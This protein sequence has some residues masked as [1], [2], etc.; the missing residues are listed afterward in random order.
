MWWALRAAP[1]RR[2]CSVSFARAGDRAEELLDQ[3]GVEVR[4]SRSGGSR[5]SNARNGRPETSIAQAARASSIGT[6]AC[7]K[8]RDAGAVAERLVERLAEHDAH[9]LD[10][11]VGAGLEVALDRRRRGRARRGARRA[12]SMWSKKPTPVPRSPAPVPSSVERRARRR[13]RR[14]SRW[15][16]GGAAHAPALHRLGVHGEAL[17]AGQ[18]GAGGREAGR[19]LAGQ[20]YA[21][22]AAPEGRRATARAGSARRRPWAAR[23]WS[24]RRSRRTPCRAAGADEHAAGARERVGQRLGLGADQL[25]VLGRD[26]LGERE[27]LR[28]RPARHHRERRSATSGARRQAL[29]LGRPRR[30]APRRARYR[31]SGLSAPCSAWASRSSATSSGSAPSAA[32]TTSS[33]GPGEPVDAHVAEHLALGL[34]TQRVARARD[35]VDRRAR[36]RCRRPARRSPARRPSGRPR[37]PA[38]HAGGEDHRVGPA[39]GPRRRAHRYLAAPRPR[40]RSP[41]T[42][43]R[44]TD[45]PPGRPARR[46]PRGRPA[47]RRPRRCWPCGQLDRDRLA[48]LRLAPPRARSRSPC[49]GRRARRARARPRDASSSRASHPQLLGAAA[50]PCRSAR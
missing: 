6:T 18:G 44:W 48:Q 4:R 2:T 13:S 12:S 39:A 5:A 27:R 19:R 8:R 3:V 36:S 43:P 45:T 38:E 11:V 34:L 37:Y 15:I 24:R 42:S 33:L 41:R 7:P 31:H 50:P 10:R 40:A 1:P 25:E 16:V 49:A 14:W 20:G 26:L 28:E 22:H 46:R 30:A 35:H 17:G 9:V 23:G 21:S 47:P 32:T 29:G